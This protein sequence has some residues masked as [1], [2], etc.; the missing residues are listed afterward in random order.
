MHLVVE[1]CDCAYSTASIYGNNSVVVV[2]RLI[3]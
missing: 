1:Y 2:D 3:D